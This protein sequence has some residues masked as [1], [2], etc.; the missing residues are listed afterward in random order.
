MRCVSRHPGLVKGSALPSRPTRG[1]AAFTLMELLVVVAIIALLL[2]VLAPS[3][4]QAKDQARATLC[5]TNLRQMAVAAQTYAACEQS[6]YPI[7]YYYSAD[8]KVS[9]AWDFISRQIGGPA[10]AET[11]VEPGLLWQGAGPDMRIH[12]CPSFR[13]SSNSPG[14]PYTGYN[15]N[16]SYIGHGQYESIP[17]P[18]KLEDVKSPGQCALFG[19]GQYAA[20]ANKF[21]RAPRSNPGDAQFSDA[22]RYAGT[23]GYRHLGRTNVSFCD[24]H[25][26]SWGECHTANVPNVASGT[27]F[28]SPDNRMYDTE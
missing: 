17:A 22:F 1:S 15:Y 28:L 20:G 8:M 2:G 23:Q 11:A 26:A 9:Y 25:A 27:G 12:Q 10:G 19:D 24:G 21:M 3:L 7:A 18:A 5:L 4:S 13:G 14:D 16:T 6:C